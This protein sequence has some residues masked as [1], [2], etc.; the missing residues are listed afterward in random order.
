MHI[1]TDIYN[2]V[3]SFTGCPVSQIFPATAC[4]GNS[5]CNYFGVEQ[6]H[7][8]S[9]P[10]SAVRLNS[11]SRL[12]VGTLHLYVTDANLHAHS[13]K[14]FNHHSN[15][16]DTATTSSDKLRREELPVLQQLLRRH[17]CLFIFHGHLQAGNRSTQYR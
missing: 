4:D 15:Q 11:N 1:C 12:A 5:Y 16:V 2:Y 14:L 3:P 7:T 6:V 9:W 17:T 13:P 10:P 8:Y